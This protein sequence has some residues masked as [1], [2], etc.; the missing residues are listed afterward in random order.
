TIQEYFSG[1]DLFQNHEEDRLGEPPRGGSAR[2]HQSSHCRIH[3]HIFLCFRRR[4]IRHGHRQ[5]SR[6]HIGRTFGGRGG[7]CPC[8]GG[9]DICGPYLRWPP[10]PRCHHRPTFRRS[11]QCLPRIPL[12]DRSAVGLLRSLLPP[13]L[14]HWRNG[15]FNIT[16]INK[17]LIN[18]V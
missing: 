12:L 5:L 4:R 11:H 16:K 2:L 1:L 15:T 3:H 18:I 13:K 10:Q 7:S 6:K 14:P 17:T 8:S 9:H